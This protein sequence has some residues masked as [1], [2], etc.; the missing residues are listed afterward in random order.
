M[1]YFPARFLCTACGRAAPT[2]L[3]LSGS[4]EV[5]AFSVVREAPIGFE[6]FAPYCVAL[7]RLDDGPLVAAQLTDVKPE[8]VYIG[9]RVEKVTRKLREYGDSGI[10]AYGYKFR[11]PLTQPTN[12]RRSTTEL[13]DTLAWRGVEAQTSEQPVA[14]PRH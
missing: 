12:G 7:V 2:R 6:E 10:I 11:P 5:Y 14:T 1:T 9:M 13:Q 8:E 4:G 3:R